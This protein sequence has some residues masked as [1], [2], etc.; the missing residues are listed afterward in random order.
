[1]NRFNPVAISITVMATCLIFAATSG[2]AETSQKNPFSAI[3][4][5]T[6]SNGYTI[7]LAQNPQSNSTAIRFEVNVGTI[8][9]SPTEVGS[10]HLLEHVLFKGKLGPSMSYLQLIKEAGGDANGETGRESTSFY[11]SIPSKKGQWLLESLI[12]MLSKPQITQEAVDSEKGAVELERGS[13]GPV[14]SLFGQSLLDIL[15]PRY[16]E[17]K[18]VLQSE[19]GIIDRE[20]SLS[21]EQYSTRRLTAPV[22]QALY[23]RYYYPANVTIYVAGAFSR[24]DVL[25]TIENIPANPDQVHLKRNDRAQTIVHKDAPYHRTRVAEDT[26]LI[27]VG[28]KLYNSSIQDRLVTQAYLE[29]LAHSLMKDLRNRKGQ[30]YTAHTYID[31]PARSGYAAI[32][33]E[34]PKD[35]FWENFEFVL[36]RVKAEAQ[37]GQISDEKVREVISLFTKNLLSYEQDN[38]NLIRFARSLDFYFRIY[39][40][41][42]R[43]PID[44]I[45]TL[46]PSE[47]RS[48]LKENFGEQN[49]Y[50]ELTAP[51]ILFPYDRL[52]LY[53]ATFLITLR[54]FRSFA[55]RPFKNDRVLWIRKLVFPPIRIVETT[56]VIAV[57]FISIHF[58]LPLRLLAESLPG[59]LS[60][61]TWDYFFAAVQVSFS[62]LSCLMLLAKLPRK[63][64][65]V[66]NH[67]VIKSV[68]YASLWIPLSEIARIE[69]LNPIEVLTQELGSKLRFLYFRPSLWKTGILIKLK[70]GRAYYLGLTKPDIACLELR[71]LVAEIHKP[72]LKI[73]A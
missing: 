49:S 18:S 48:I 65:V 27:R 47:F 29:Y 37:G 71:S 12:H 15:F 73:G 36:D 19:F 63:A 61:R 23:S 67:L 53:L 41:S 57:L 13:P 30:T 6:A 7:Y 69:E 56:L 55:L 33:F 45:E 28:T 10:A 5:V 4:R 16:L 51:A 3:E 60:L 25:A 64:M 40:E 39:G 46:N 50:V 2:A 35:S 8:D 43:S 24:S 20:P 32:S 34:T 44:I 11:A 9:E 54:A 21:Q 1:M 62:T 14:A 42:K 58:K 26:P 70:S 59:V 31:I 66:D 72:A 38:E 68:T 17:S 52:L 22:L